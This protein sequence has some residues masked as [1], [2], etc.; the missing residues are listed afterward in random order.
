M[1]A[2]AIGN[3]GLA[4][5][6][7]QVL[8][9]ITLAFLFGMMLVLTGVLRLGF[10]ANFL[11][12]PVIA[13]FITASGIIIAASQ[14]KHLFGIEASGH[15]L[16]ELMASMTAHLDQ[17]NLVTLLIGGAAA[18][19]NCWGDQ[20]APQGSQRGIPPHRDQRPGDGSPAT[21]LIPGQPVRGGISISVSGYK[22]ASPIADSLGADRL[23]K[24]R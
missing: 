21:H 7:E 8:A 6:E 4:T 3:L 18:L 5:I 15:T 23:T 19:W 12:R 14:L 2:T 22:G 9:A 11:S 1:T 24:V 20:S 13:G 17:A 16:Y 10:L